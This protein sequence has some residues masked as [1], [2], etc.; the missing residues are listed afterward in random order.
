MN[1]LTPLVLLAY[2]LVA[3][4]AA[5]PAASGAQGGTQGEERPGGEALPAYGAE[6]EGFDYPYPV[7]HYA[8]NSQ[9]QALQ[10]A[11]MDVVPE[12]PNGRTIVL[13][14]GK[15]FCAGTWAGT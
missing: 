9:R 3:L 8:F 7:H 15:N 6:L 2:C 4:G 13:L 12:H 14:H 1:R 10:M 5:A 11:Y